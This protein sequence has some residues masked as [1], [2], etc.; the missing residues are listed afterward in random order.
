MGESP[1]RCT[2]DIADVMHFLDPELQRLPR[3]ENLIRLVIELRNSLSLQ[4][5]GAFYA[6][7]TMTGGALAWLEFSNHSDRLVPRW[8]FNRL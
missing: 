4:N 5:I 6:W 3:F 1:E 7:M 8:E 2:A